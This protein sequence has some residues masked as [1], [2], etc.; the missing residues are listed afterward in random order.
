MFK[1]ESNFWCLNVVVTSS[2]HRKLISSNYGP[3]VCSAELIK[4]GGRTIH[5]EIYKLF[6]SIWNKEELPEERR[7][8]IN[9]P[10]YKKGNKK[11]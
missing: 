5:S 6:N 9:V 2:Q 3:A 7:E 11:D 10:I 1:A 8:L 4:A